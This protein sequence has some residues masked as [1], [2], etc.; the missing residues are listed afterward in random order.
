M[1][2]YDLFVL[3]N[4]LLF[5]QTEADPESL[6][7]GTTAGRTSLWVECRLCALGMAQHSLTPS[8]HLSV[9]TL[10]GSKLLRPKF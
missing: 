4:V 1:T 10:S 8:P 9:A 7:H 5:I 2:S 6:G 3:T